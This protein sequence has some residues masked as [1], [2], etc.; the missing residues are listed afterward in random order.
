M[1]H[2][3]NKKVLNPLIQEFEGLSKQ[4]FS[5]ER[6]YNIDNLFAQFLR[7]E[8][9][10]GTKKFD[11]STHKNVRTRSFRYQ[12]D[13]GRCDVAVEMK[14]YLG[15]PNRTEFISRAIFRKIQTKKAK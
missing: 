3:H 15:Q 11:D 4:P 2:T 6:E 9:S 1:H 13:D 10:A 8:L 7:V 14:M 5:R 12:S